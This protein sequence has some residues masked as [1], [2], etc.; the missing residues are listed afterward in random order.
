MTITTA[1]DVLAHPFLP[2]LGFSCE[3]KKTCVHR[4]PAPLTSFGLGITSGSEYFKQNPMAQQLVQPLLVDSAGDYTKFF[5][6]TQTKLT[7]L[8]GRGIFEISLCLMT[9]ADADTFTSSH[10]LQPLHLPIKF[11]LEHLRR[12]MRERS[13]SLKEWQNMNICVVCCSPLEGDST[14]EAGRKD[15]HVCSSFCRAVYGYGVGRTKLSK[16]KR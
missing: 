4:R 13:S 12:A 15:A 10:I 9:H 14:I 6:T 16:V 8:Y 11:R 7:E 2:F 3:G 5:S 1:V